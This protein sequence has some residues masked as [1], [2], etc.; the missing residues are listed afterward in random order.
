MILIL[1]VGPSLAL[2]QAALELGDA[3]W[4]GMN[5]ALGLFIGFPLA[6]VGYLMFSRHRKPQTR[7]VGKKLLLAATVLMVQIFS[8]PIGIAFRNLEVQRA[9]DYCQSL[10]PALHRNYEQTGDYP[11]ELPK[12]TAGL[13]RLLQGQ[14]FYSVSDGT[15]RFSFTEP[16]TVPPTL[17]EYCCGLDGAWTT[18]TQTP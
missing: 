15:F 13:P 3:T 4:G 11:L 9:R 1:V 17:H 2:L 8:L 14:T 16:Q 18:S 6:V 7:A 5:V 12:G 10:I